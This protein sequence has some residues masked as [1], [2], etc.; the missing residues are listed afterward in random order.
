[1]SSIQNAITIHVKHGS[2]QK[3]P[4]LFTY[5]YLKQSSITL[6]TRLCSE[7]NQECNICLHATCISSSQHHGDFQDGESKSSA[8]HILCKP[9]VKQEIQ[10]KQIVLFFL[11]VTAKTHELWDTKCIQLLT[12]AEGLFSTVYGQYSLP[13]SILV[14]CPPASRTA[15]VK[16]NAAPAEIAVEMLL[17]ETL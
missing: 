16:A 13:L 17:A 10:S 8:A 3:A 1:M 9:K 6:L 12:G 15:E 7:S 11:S 2:S 14:V 4:S 5:L